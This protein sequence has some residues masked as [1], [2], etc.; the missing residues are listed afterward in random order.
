VRKLRLFWLLFPSYLIVTLAAILAVGLVSIRTARSSYLDQV[1]RD[2]AAQAY[3]VS[4]A[5]R[6]DVAGGDYEAV[7]RRCIALGRPSATRV[8]IVLPDGEVA[9]DSEESPQNMD[10]H[11]DR[12]EIRQ[13]LAEGM[14]SSMR[15]SHTL[16]ETMMYVAVGIP[17][18]GGYIAIA[19]T[20][21]PL[22][23]IAQ[24]IRKITG[25]I[26]LGVALAT[27]FA[28]AVGYVAA[29]RMV[30]P[31]EA[32][33]A[34]AERFA[35]GDFS[36]RIPP[37]AR[38]QEMAGLT[39][40]LNAM[41]EEM[42]DRIRNLVRERNQR[43]AVL[44]SMVEGVLAVD[45]QEGI[46]S[47]NSAAARFLGIELTDAHGRK[48]YD[49]VRHPAFLQF[50]R[51]AL[52]SGEPIEGEI[53]IHTQEEQLLQAHGAVL[54]NAQEGAIG[55]VVVLNDVTR[56]RR[57]ER[58]R[59]D[60]V[61]NVSHELRTPITSI[62]GFVET[63]LDGAIDNTE[64]AQRF[65]EI[66]GKHADR[67]N[68]IISDLLT[69]S[70]IEQG[71]ER[72]GIVLERVPV[73]QPLQS[74]IQL[75]KSKAA[76]KRIETVLRCEEGITARINPPL[77]EQAV[78]NLIDNAVKYSEPDSQVRVTATED[79]EG[80]MI[81]VKD[82]GCGIAEEHLPRLFERFYRIDKARSRNLGGTGLGLA[83]VKHI[84]KAHGGTVSVTSTPGKGS[85]FTI[86][87]PKA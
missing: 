82:D 28:A 72:T 8:T 5:L 74:A 40:A 35:Q 41:A 1:R 85:S 12:P 52:K 9:G 42:D 49:L 44:S 77:L 53:A 73:L 69:L 4:D 46:I 61:A 29:R 75:C 50:L 68:A 54:Q 3:L 14:G 36:Q 31:I 25:E 70:R 76:D 79:G 45:T 55:A 13:A 48:V 39:N 47:L 16:G 33:R 7:N 43:E 51:K 11:A 59:R 23:S 19:R 38:S 24:G 18:N 62:K 87:L 58:V 78:A 21:V 83:I 66:I 22:T 64:D 57:L 30:R 15:F 34:G 56:L 10:N 20:A 71:E 6:A 26:T 32:V 65:L 17:R 63:L 27:L 60:F 80:V 81:R 37:V 84:V 86:R 67:L 2:L